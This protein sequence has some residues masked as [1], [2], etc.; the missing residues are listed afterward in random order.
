MRAVRVDV[1]HA[2]GCVMFAV[3]FSH[4]GG[5]VVPDVCV[6]ALVDQAVVVEDTVSLS[7]CPHCLGIALAG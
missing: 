2:C 6:N 7:L 1:D 5:S 4:V 3:V